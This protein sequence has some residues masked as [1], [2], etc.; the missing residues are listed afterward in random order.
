MIVKLHGLYDNDHRRIRH[1]SFDGSFRSSPPAS[2]AMLA[3]N[4][5]LAM[6]PAGSLSSESA[7]LVGVGAPIGT[8]L[9]RG[10]P[11]GS[12]GSA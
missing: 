10:R 1:S 7:I 3:I 5:L 12:S 6:S 11:C 2:S 9:I 4:G 8:F